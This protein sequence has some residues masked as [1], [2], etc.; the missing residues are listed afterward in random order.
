MRSVA[1]AACA[2]NK[3]GA[4]KQILEATV[5]GCFRLNQVASRRA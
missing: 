4:F 2:R 5:E 3:G 1:K